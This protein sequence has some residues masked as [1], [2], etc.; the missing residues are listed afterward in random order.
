MP[1]TGGDTPD[2]AAEPVAEPAAERPSA[3]RSTTGIAVASAVVALSAFL[4]QWAVGRFAAPEVT[5]EFLVYWALLFAAFGV[6]GG[7]RNETTRAVGA[8]RATGASGPRALTAALVVGGAGALMLLAT[9]PAWAER[10]VPSTAPAIVPVIA[11]AA[12]LYACHVSVLGA[13][14]GRESWGPM[15]ATMAVEATVRLAGVGAVLLVGGG[16]L[17]LELAVAVSALT[18]AVLVAL[19]PEVRRAAAARTDVGLGRLLRNSGYTVAA[20]V[21]SS[22]LITGFPVLMQLTSRDADAVV[23]AG[24]ILAVSLTRSPIMIPLQAFQ[25]YA[26]VAFLHSERHRLRALARPLAA[27]AAVG[28]VA[29][30]AAWLLGPWVM[31][32]LFAGRY[33]I[34]GSTFA[35]LMAAAA[36]LAMLTLTGTAALADGA[37]AGYTAGWAVAALAAAALLLLPLGLAERTVIALVVGPVAGTAL[38]L[39][40]LARGTGGGTGGGASR[41]A[42]TP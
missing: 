37:H 21:A 38:H 23:L 33:E 15:S 25:G 26:I 27:L 22:V 42:R 18:W 16:L 13:L 34:A 40:A 31:D 2:R 19:S 35:G 9:A 7:V 24:T 30:V 29:A 12:V 20:S 3:R 10:L 6:I 11:L 1:E 4:V 28:A 39:A 14:S 41:G 32:L 8:A 5:A 36:T 17:P